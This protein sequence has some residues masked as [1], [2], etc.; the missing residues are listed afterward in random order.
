MELHYKGIN[1]FYTDTGSGS[2]VVLLHG[3]L[4]NS[5]M[6]NFIVPNLSQKHRVITIDLLGHGQ[7]DCLGYV[8]SMEAMAY[9]VQAVLKHLKIRCSVFVGHSMG[10]YVALAFA[11]LFPLNVKRL[12]LMNSTFLGDSDER[13]QLRDRAIQAAK[14]NYKSLVSMSIA[15]LFHVDSLERYKAEIITAKNDAL[16]TPLQGYIAAQEGMK[17]RKDRT[18]VLKTANFKTLIIV[19]KQDPILT[20]KLSTFEAEELHAEVS[21]IEGGHMSHIENRD[22]L[23]IQ[24]MHFIEK[25]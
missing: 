14:T 8:H 13:I 6:W 19:G 10:G 1:I 24:I 16:K 18:A 17:I 25:K 12:C 9:A 11:E 23:F 22:E 5:S 20:L 2:A 21:E 4:E 15:N 3:F 7:T